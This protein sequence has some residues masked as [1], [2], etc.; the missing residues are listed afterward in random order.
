MPHTKHIS[1]TFQGTE[2]C[3]SHNIPCKAY[4]LSFLRILGI[5][6]KSIEVPGTIFQ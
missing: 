1:S 2:H 5:Q 6:L 4:V 3:Y